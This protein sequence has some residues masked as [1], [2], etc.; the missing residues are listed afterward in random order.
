MIAKIKKLV[1]RIF[2]ERYNPKKFKS[3]GKN[4]HI[5]RGNRFIAPQHIEIGDN[6]YIGIGGLYFGMGGLKIG[7]GTS[8]AHKVEII[9]FNHAYDYEGLKSIPF[10]KHY[11]YEPVTIGENVWIGSNVN[12]VPGVTVEEGAVVGMGAVVTKNVPK[13]AVVGGNPAKIIK[14]RDTERYEKLKSEHKIKIVSRQ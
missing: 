5:E 3:F 4:V 7:S 11:T 1:K 6:V 9:T 12:I 10:D 14:F 2:F 13:Y 8:I